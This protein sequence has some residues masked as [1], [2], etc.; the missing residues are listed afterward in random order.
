MAGKVLI[1]GDGGPT[2]AKED[3]AQIY[4]A[5][6]V[7][8][9]AELNIE[10]L[11]AG[12]PRIRK[13]L[14]GAAKGRTLEVGIG[15]GRNLFSYPKRVTSLTGVDI[16]ARML[17][18][19]KEKIG[20][21]QQGHRNV[22]EGTPCSTHGR[23]HYFRVEDA[24]SLTFEDDRFDTV[25]DTFSCAM[26]VRVGDARG[27]KGVQRSCRHRSRCLPRPTPRHTSPTSPAHLALDSACA[28]TKIRCRLFA[29]CNVSASRMATS[30][31]LSTG[32]RDR[33]PGRSW[34]ATRGSMKA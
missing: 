16:S 11:A 7:V 1:R 19:A 29:R 17:D 4:D 8:Y 9:D 20:G 30:S 21:G 31:C 5:A 28:A 24:E 13:R 3:T 2:W 34:A 6:A 12:V 27:R 26:R 15:T 32:D 25:V 33:R 18:Q 23:R 14:L 22:S 10:E